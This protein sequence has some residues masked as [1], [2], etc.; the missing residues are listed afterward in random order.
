MM[1]LKAWSESHKKKFTDN[2]FFFLQYDLSVYIIPLEESGGKS[3]LKSYIEI[4][5]LHQITVIRR[6]SSNQNKNL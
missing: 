3:I 2:F 5:L 6:G 1:K 4:R